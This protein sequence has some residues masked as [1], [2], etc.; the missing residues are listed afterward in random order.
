[1]YVVKMF[2]VLGRLFVHICRGE[3]TGEG[4]RPHG[5][6]QSCK[7]T[8]KYLFGSFQLEKHKA[9]TVGSSSDC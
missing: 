2:I 8:K 4:F 5:K 7:F 1:M 6:A 9:T 3:S